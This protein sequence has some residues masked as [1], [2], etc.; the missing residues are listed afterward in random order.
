VTGFALASEA[1]IL[2]TALGILA[3]LIFGLATW[4]GRWPL[5]VVGW[6]CAVLALGVALLLHV[7]RPSTGPN[8]AGLG[9][10]TVAMA[11]GVSP[12]GPTPRNTTSGHDGARLV[13]RLSQS[14]PGG[15]GCRSGANRLQW[16]PVAPA[17]CQGAMNHE[18][19]PT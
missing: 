16:S 7:R 10:G 11:P 12:D 14:A 3:L 1:L 4:F 6:I 15:D 8:P 17:Q 2:S 9:P 5:W 13:S 19:R 18:D